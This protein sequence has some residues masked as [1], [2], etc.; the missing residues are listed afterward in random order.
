MLRLIPDLECLDAKALNELLN[1]KSRQPTALGI[2]ID[3]SAKISTED[4]ALLEY[5]KLRLIFSELHTFIVKCAKDS[6]A[7]IHDNCERFHFTSLPRVVLFK[8][9]NAGYDIHY[10][11]FDS[12]DCQIRIK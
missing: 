1:D 9:G 4:V 8:S 5:K 3:N 2:F 6:P 7:S 10:S 11:E 12:L